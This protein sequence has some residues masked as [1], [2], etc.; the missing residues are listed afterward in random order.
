MTNNQALN[1][2]NSI[3]LNPT[4]PQQAQNPIQQA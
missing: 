4:T 3:R 2:L 1:V